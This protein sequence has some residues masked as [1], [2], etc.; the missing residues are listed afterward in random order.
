M[1]LPRCIKRHSRM[2]PTIGRHGKTRFVP[3]MNFK[4][5]GSLRSCLA[6]SRT[7]EQTNGFLK[8]HLFPARQLIECFFVHLEHVLKA[9]EKKQHFPF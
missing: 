5:A 2:A 9:H 7:L 3:G 1:D 6:H 8:V 4:H